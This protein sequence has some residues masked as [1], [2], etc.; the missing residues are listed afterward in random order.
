M[1]LPPKPCRKCGVGIAHTGHLRCW[2]CRT[3]RRRGVHNRD[4]RR[5]KRLCHG[6]GRL[7]TTYGHR[8]CQ[9]CRYPS[10]R[11]RSPASGPPRVGKPRPAE[12]PDC[13]GDLPPPAEPMPVTADRAERVATLER[14]AASRVG[15]WHPA[16]RA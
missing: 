1:H 12:V 2:A 14:R 5:T 8:L 7:A 6:C 13:W 4:R 10:G 3:V 11:M 15:L 16:D 9:G